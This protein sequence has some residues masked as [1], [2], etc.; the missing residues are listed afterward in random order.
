MRVAE[1]PVFC[2]ARV[3]ALGSLDG[4]DNDAKLLG[5]TVIPWTDLRQSDNVFAEVDIRGVLDSTAELHWL[6]GDA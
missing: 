5:A 1:T 2:R 6:S 3:T 4:S